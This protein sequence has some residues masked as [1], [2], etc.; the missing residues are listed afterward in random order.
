MVEN[1]KMVYFMILNKKRVK[2]V[3]K[4]VFLDLS[5][6]VRKFLKMKKKIQVKIC[7]TPFTPFTLFDENTLEY[8]IFLSFLILCSKI[9][10]SRLKRFNL[11]KNLKFAKN[12]SKSDIRVTQYL[13]PYMFFAFGPIYKPFMGERLQP[14]GFESLQKK[15][16]KKVPKG[17]YLKG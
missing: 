10:I 5:E 15:G 1:R 6:K 2:G 14:L 13:S 4:R 8:L 11:V 9:Y 7:C 16:V 17:V 3:W 12:T